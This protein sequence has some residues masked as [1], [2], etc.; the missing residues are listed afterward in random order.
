M[1]KLCLGRRSPEGPGLV[2]EAGKSVA[3]PA[4]CPQAE[5]CGWEKCSHQES[6]TALFSPITL[7]N[8]HFLRA[9]LQ[10]PHTTLSWE[11]MTQSL[12]LGTLQAL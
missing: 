2:T 7:L 1:E 9:S 6:L 5:M 3:L 11:F 4:K 8:I 10:Q 12:P